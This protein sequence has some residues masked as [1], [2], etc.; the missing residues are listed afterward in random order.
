MS[1][2]V[3]IDFGTTNSVVAVMEGGETVVIPNNR[4]ERLTPS[5]VSFG[6]GGEILVGTA[7]K[8]QAIINFERTVVSVKR[9]FGTEF[10]LGVDD[11]KYNPEQI[12]AIVI[13][14]LKESAEEFIGEEVRS[15]VITVPAYFNDGQRQSVK[16]AGEMAGL[17]VMRLINEPTAAA[18]AYNMPRG[19]EG[20]ILVFDL[21][22]GTFDVSI[23]DVSDTVYEVIATAGN[24]KLGGDD[25]DTALVHHFCSEFYQQHSIDLREDLMALQKIRDA[26][27]QAKKELSESDATTVNV[28]FISADKDGPKHLEITITRTGFENLI[29]KHL[30]EIDELV[31]RAMEDADVEAE[32]IDRVILV[33]GSTRVP[34]VQRLLDDRFAGRV[35]KNTNPDECV[36]AGAAIQAGIMSGSVKGLVLVDVTP[37]TLGI[38][39]EHDVFVPIIERNS[40]IPTSQ[41]RIFTTVTDN[42][43]EVEIHVVQGER[44][45]ASKN[46]SLGKFTLEDIEPARRGTP[47]IEVLFDI[48]VNGIVH[49]SAKDQRTGNAKKI[50]VSPREKLSEEEI[51]QIVSDAEQHRRD[52]EV[53]LGRR[54]LIKQARTLLVLLKTKAAS[55][56]ISDDDEVP[57]I[58][59]LVEYI[60]K[61]M[62]GDDIEQIRNAIETMNVY[63]NELAVA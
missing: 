29:R 41:N 1:R 9:K 25:F 46:Y 15:A 55:G 12:A 36:A 45:Q 3:G 52:D 56:D 30:D 59:E 62:Q 16:K 48:D 8:N 37:L 51:E 38:E 19:G 49:V 17:E 20:A 2:A 43:N 26:A 27:E 23:L 10:S 33:G 7:A 42:Q 14:R 6:G 34:A 24:N 61:V 13:G 11:K 28:P 22:G 63:L 40:C 54:Q 47:R 53:F 39:T 21:G 35:M 44:S 60:E 57:E 5:V 32:D 58:N 18:L 50:E 4:G 31:V